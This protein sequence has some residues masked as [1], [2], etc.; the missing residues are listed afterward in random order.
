MFVIQ[1]LS[2]ES[3]S[4]LGVI[5]IQLRHIQIIDKVDEESFTLW[6]PS[7]TSLLLERRQTKL[8]LQDISIGIVI[9]I[10]DVEEIVLW[11]FGVEIFQ[12]TFDDLG[13][14]TTSRS[15]QTDGILGGDVVPHELLESSSLW[16]WNG[17]I[18]HHLGLGI[19]L[20]GSDIPFTE[21]EVVTISFLDK[22]DVEDCTDSGELDISFEFSHPEI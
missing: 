16:S 22:V 11:L 14:T 15:N 5:F 18:L 7:D 17:N 8:N 2:E 12:E 13:L 9:E 6:S 3:D 21:R 1:E 4:G 19:E 20:N 10:D